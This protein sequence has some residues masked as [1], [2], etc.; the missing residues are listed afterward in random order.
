MFVWAYH[1]VEPEDVESGNLLD[2]CPL[3]LST[4]QSW[5]Q[6]YRIWKFVRPMSTW[7]QHIDKFK[8]V[9]SDNSLDLYPRGLGFVATSKGVGLESEL[10]PCH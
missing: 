7:A 5:A 3:G 8:D 9:G 6:G 2:P 1:V 4:A 10:D